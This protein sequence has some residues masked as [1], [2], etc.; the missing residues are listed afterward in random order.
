A[1]MRMEDRSGRNLHQCGRAPRVVGVIIQ[2][3]VETLAADQFHAEVVLVFE[4]AD[5]ENRHDVGVIESGDRLGLVVKPAEANRAALII[6]RATERLRLSW[7]A[8]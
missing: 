7:R 3:L 5:L 8:L 4:L 2:P 1:L 6:F